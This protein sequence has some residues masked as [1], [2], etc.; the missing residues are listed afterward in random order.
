MGLQK[1]NYTLPN[2]LFSESVYIK[3]F[4]ISGNGER[5]AV[6]VRYYVSREAS[7]SGI[8]AIEVRN[9]TLKPSLESGS[10]NFI[11]Q[12]YK[13][14]KSLPEY[15]GAIDVLEEGQST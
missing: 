9:Y 8:S 12:G 4:H 2:G 7:E 10:S 6:D 5:L 14:L 1:S 13:Y 15:E 11:K 3:I